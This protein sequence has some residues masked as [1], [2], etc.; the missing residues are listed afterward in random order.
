MV[1]CYH[2]DRTK[3]VKNGNMIILLLRYWYSNGL[4]KQVGVCGSFMRFAEHGLERVEQRTQNGNGE[5]NQRMSMDA[6]TAHWHQPLCYYCSS[7]DGS[8]QSNSACI[9]EGTNGHGIWTQHT[10]SKLIAP[11]PVQPLWTRP[12]QNWPLRAT[13]GPAHLLPVF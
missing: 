11:P 12:T 13:N 8:H 9:T 6:A 2:H 5:K 4:S 1:I 7:V 3:F 10:N